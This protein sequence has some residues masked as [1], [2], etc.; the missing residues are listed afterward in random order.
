MWEANAL[1]PRIAVE[2][3]AA[4]E[5]RRVVVTS[6]VGGVGPVTGRAAGTEDA[7]SAAAG[8]GSPTSTAKHEGEAE[9][10]AAGAR[11]GIEVVIVNPSYVFGVPVDRSQPGENS[12]RM[13][14]NYLRGRLPGVVDGAHQHSSTCGRR[15]GPPAGCRAGP[16]GERYI[17]GGENLSWVELIERVAELSGV[18]P[19]RVR[20]PA[21][22]GRRVAAAGRSV[23]ESSSR[24]RPLC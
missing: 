15:L 13:I 17:L 18:Q 16:P 24:P 7:V 3:A 8:S 22:G 6:S 11:C 9:A 2:A 1:A 19:S 14:G 21:R 4:E 23:A 12:T 10:I 5:V 20:D